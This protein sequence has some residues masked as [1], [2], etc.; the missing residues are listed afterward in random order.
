[1]N[2]LQYNIQRSSNSKIFETVGT[3]A[4]KGINGYEF[5]DNIQRVNA[6]TLYYRIEAVD[7]NGAKS[8][9]EVKQVTINKEQL[10]VNIYPNPVRNELHIVVDSKA[11][12]KLYNIAGKQF[13]T[14]ALTQGD[15]NINIQQLS[16]GV[17]VAVIETA[18]GVVTMKIIKEQ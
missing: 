3:I 17:Y 13:T 6:N 18:N 4:A 8:Y 14:N 9:S 7:V 11:T 5:S 2:L 15:N 16:Q 1:M 12:I 10:V